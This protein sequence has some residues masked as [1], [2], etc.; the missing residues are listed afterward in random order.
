MLLALT[1]LAFAASDADFFLN[2]DVMHWGDKEGLND[3][4]KHHQP[5]NVAEPLLLS[6]I[7]IESGK[8]AKST[9][10]IN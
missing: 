1:L 5:L 2:L 8:I 7:P 4:G 6:L 9:L 3:K 10:F